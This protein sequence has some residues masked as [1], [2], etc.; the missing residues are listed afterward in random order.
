M[1]IL[2][3]AKLTRGTCYV[4]HPCEIDNLMFSVYPIGMCTTSQLVLWH[5]TQLSKKA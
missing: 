4:V 5:F 2:N 3:L 1:V